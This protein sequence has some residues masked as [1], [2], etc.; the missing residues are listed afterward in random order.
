MGGDCGPAGG[1]WSA[2]GPGEAGRGAASGERVGVAAGHKN[3]PAPAPMV[4][5]TAAAIGTAR[6]VFWA[7]PGAAAGGAAGGLFAAAA[8]TGRALAGFADGATRMVASSSIGAGIL[9]SS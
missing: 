6:F 3:Q 7:G 5:S 8:S 2:S 4:R 9:A 1:V